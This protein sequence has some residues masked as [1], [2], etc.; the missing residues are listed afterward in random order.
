MIFAI[1]AYL[2]LF[3][4]RWYQS[5]KKIFLEWYETLTETKL[6]LSTVKIL[7]GILE[8]D[9]PLK[10]TNYLL[11]IAKYYTYTVVAL[12]KNPCILALI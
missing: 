2:C 8:D 5:S 3:H 4:V 6:E 12:M 7:H 10:L 9:R 11:L 1:Y